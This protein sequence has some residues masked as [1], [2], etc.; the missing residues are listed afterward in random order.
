MMNMGMTKVQMVSEMV[1]MVNWP[2]Q[3]KQREIKSA[4]SKNTK[5]R[6][7]EVYNYWLNHK[8]E[9]LFCITIL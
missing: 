3:K 6:I 4:V 1:E 5:S 8:N 7:E 9:S 2:D